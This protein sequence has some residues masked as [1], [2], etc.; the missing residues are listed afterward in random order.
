M[1]S[2]Y[3]DFKTGETILEFLQETGLITSQVVESTIALVESELKYQSMLIE[4]AGPRVGDVGVEYYQVRGVAVSFETFKRVYTNFDQYDTYEKAIIGMGINPDKFPEDRSTRDR[5]IRNTLGKMRSY[6]AKNGFGEFASPSDRKRAYSIRFA[7]VDSVSAELD[8]ATYDL[9][10]MDDI[11]RGSRTRVVGK[12]GKIIKSINDNDDIFAGELYN[13]ISRIPP[14][15]WSSWL[16]FWDRTKTPLPVDKAFL[17]KEWRK[18]FIVGYQIEPNVVYEIWYNSIDS[19]FSVHDIRGTEVVR[20]GAT[21]NEAMNGLIKFL[22]Q[23][24]PQDREVFMNANNAI[25]RSTARTLIQ[26]IDGDDR[27]KSLMRREK[28]AEAEYRKAVSDSNKRAKE[29]TD[30]L[31]AMGGQV[32]STTTWVAKD[33]IRAGAGQIADTTIWAGELAGQAGRYMAPGV[34]AG[35]EEIAKAADRAARNAR[36]D[37]RSET[38]KEFNANA[39]SGNS[40][41]RTNFDGSIEGE[42]MDN[43]TQSRGTIGISQDAVDGEVSRAAK[44]SV[45]AASKTNDRRNKLLAALDDINDQDTPSQKPDNGSEKRK[46]QLLK[47]IQQTRDEQNPNTITEAFNDPEIDKEIQSSVVDFSETSSYKAKVRQMQQEYRNKSNP[48]TATALSVTFTNTAIETYNATRA[49]EKEL[50]GGMFTRI[51]RKAPIVLPTDKPSVFTRLSNS[52]RGTRYAADFIV[53]YTVQDR[54]NIEVWYITEPNPDYNWSVF[55]ISREPRTISSFYVFDVTG[56][57]LLRGFLPY[58]RNAVQVVMGKMASFVV[59][60][61]RNIEVSKYQDDL[62]RAAERRRLWDQ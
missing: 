13:N 6:F 59:P 55:G 58:Y 5:F 25:A 62:D 38:E 43:P 17:A 2:E 37:S 7:G 40:S 12:S 27:M 23:I 32:K 54:L 29:Q 19:S 20:R 53:G 48:L 41:F 16:K 18:T 46:A 44:Q 61:K 21:L 33:G 52:V 10:S 8:K 26:G 50:R 60:P 31:K 15:R 39:W 34:K 56:G 14:S 9:P 3:E 22:V 30:K 4:M 49:D 45:S 11:D 35:A 1:S 36:M 42:L 47:Y 51:G 24:S 57:H 28:R